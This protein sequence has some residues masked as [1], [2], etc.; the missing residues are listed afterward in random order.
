MRFCRV[1]SLLDLPHTLHTCQPIM[2]R[3]L[4]GPSL[5]RQLCFGLLP[6]ELH[7]SALSIFLD[8]ICVSAP[9]QEADFCQKGS[10]IPLAREEMVQIDRSPALRLLQKRPN[11]AAPPWKKRPGENCEKGGGVFPPLLIFRAHQ[12]E[13]QVLLLLA[14]R[15]WP[16]LLRIQQWSRW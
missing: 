4:S 11:P 9:V 7:W 16:C 15:K 12:E 5:A 10:C 14:Q 13:S 2:T 1:V 3:I 6:S 8:I